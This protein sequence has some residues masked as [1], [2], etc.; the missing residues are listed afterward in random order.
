MWTFLKGCNPEDKKEENY[1]NGIRNHN[2]STYSREKERRPIPSQSKDSNKNRSYSR[3]RAE[4]STRQ[5]N[6]PS[7][8]FPP[9]LSRE[10]DNYSLLFWIKIWIVEDILKNDLRI[11]PPLIGFFVPHRSF[12]YITGKSKEWL[13]LQKRKNDF[14]SV[15]WFCV[16]ILY[17]SYT[18]L[19]IGDIY[20][21][22]HTPFLY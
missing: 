19:F 3:E 18:H 7:N 21:H 15:L 20:L 2:R 8:D 5:M 4:I 17:Y 22:Y 11:Y 10:I 14:I 6:A 12:T 1:R 16:K 13:A 9:N